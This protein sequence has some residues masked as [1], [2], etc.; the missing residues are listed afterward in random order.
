MADFR[1]KLSTAWTAFYAHLKQL[2]NT[3]GNGSVLKIRKVAEGEATFDA[4]PIPFLVVQLISGKTVSSIDADALWTGQV[5]IRVVSLIAAA[6]T[7]TSEILSKIAQVEDK[8]TAFV[9]P[10]GVNGFNA[11]DWSITFEYKSSQG[12]LVVADCLRDFTVAVAKGA[13]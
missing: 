5:K 8:I 7:A 13:N 1:S 11:G 4:W 6:N 12:S 3:A 9:R 2:E 10:D